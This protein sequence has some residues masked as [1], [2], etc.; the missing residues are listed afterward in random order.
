MGNLAIQDT[1][2]KKHFLKRCLASVVCGTQYIFLV[3]LL[4]FPQKFKGIEQDL[5]KS[6]QNSALILH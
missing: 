6:I 1:S 3:G 4:L 2:E 5:V